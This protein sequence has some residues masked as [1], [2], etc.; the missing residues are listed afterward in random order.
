VQVQLIVKDRRGGE[1]LPDTANINENTGPIADAGPDRAVYVRDLVQLD[2]RKSR[3]P[4]GDPITF[5]WVITKKPPESRPVLSNP[6]ILRPTFIA[7]KEG[8]YLVQ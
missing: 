4:D 7:D 1:S 3:D 2:G 5:E 6:K 8:E